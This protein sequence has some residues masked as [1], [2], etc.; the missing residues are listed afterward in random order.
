MKIA[1]IARAIEE[2]NGLQRIP[3]IDHVIV[4]TGQHY[5][6]RMSEVFFEEL[7]LPKPQ[8]N[9]DVGS[10]SHA[11]QTAEI[12]KRFEPVLLEHQPDV[13]VL[14][15]DV[16]S[17]IA[18]AL[19]ASK[20]EYQPKDNC[21]TATLQHF[22]SGSRKQ[23]TTSEPQ[24][25]STAE[26]Q[27]TRGLR[28]LVAHVEAGLRSFDRNMPEEINRILTDALSDFLFITEEDASVNLLREGI[29]SKKIHFV[30]NVMIDTLMVHL[31]KATRQSPGI[32]NDH[33]SQL[34]NGY[35]LVTLH[36]PS[37]VDVPQNLS[38][39]MDCLREISARIPVIFPIHPRT[40]SNLERIGSYQGGSKDSRMI[41]IE[42]LGYL[43]FLSLLRSAVLVLTDSGG[44]QEETTFLRVPCITLRKNTERPVTISLGTN[45]LVGTDPD[46]IL[47]TAFEVLDG[48]GK[49]GEIPPLWDGKAGQR[50]VQILVEKIVTS[51]R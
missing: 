38:V 43:E 11:V 51:D 2:H 21:S 40:R 4:H 45:T 48:K 41:L 17:T 15:G 8:I 19:V 12:M 32:L 14:V 29:G 5:D 22:P 30:G 39:L 23:G 46:K 20:I 42:P 24:N 27:H 37:N 1:S 33:S 35:A 9:L 36:R 50:I 34:R 25:C 3:P 28:P 6:D 10:A 16:N 44:I 13:V 26:Q 49:K 47:K 31:E 7:A 18:C